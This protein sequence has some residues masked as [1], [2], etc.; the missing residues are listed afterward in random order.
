MF[1]RQNLLWSSAANIFLNRTLSS[2]DILVLRVGNVL[3]DDEDADVEDDAFEDDASDNDASDDASDDC[4]S[5]GETAAGDGDDATDDGGAGDSMLVVA[6]DVLL[7]SL[8]VKT[9]FQDANPSSYVNRFVRV[10][11]LQYMI[12]SIYLQIP[13]SKVLHKPLCDLSSRSSGFHC[14]R[15]V[16]PCRR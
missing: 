2:S 5:D 6:H 3:D 11:N 12:V 10:S 16:G 4:A 8:L 15:L 1:R 13:Y 14:C 7:L 9:A